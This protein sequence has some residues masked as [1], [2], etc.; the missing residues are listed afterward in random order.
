MY[1]MFSLNQ[2]WILLVNC[3]REVREESIAHHQPHPQP[4]PQALTLAASK[5]GKPHDAKV[6]AYTMVEMSSQLQSISQH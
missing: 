3:L 6:S 2:C 4:P 1:K 5:L